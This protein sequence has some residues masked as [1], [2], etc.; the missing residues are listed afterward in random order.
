MNRCLPALSSSL[1][2]SPISLSFRAVGTREVF[3]NEV[4]T[5]PKFAVCQEAIDYLV[6]QIREIEVKLEGFKQLGM[7]IQYIHADLHYDNVMVV[8]DQVS[9]LLDFEVGCWGGVAHIKL[10]CGTCE[11]YILICTW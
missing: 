9:G 2:T 8:G 7:P 11:S 6:G 5:N 1:P 4:A 10:V 3:Y